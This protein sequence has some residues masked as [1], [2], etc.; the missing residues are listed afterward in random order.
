MN[1]TDKEKQQWI[2]VLESIRNDCL[3]S[4]FNLKRKIFLIDNTIDLT[5][6]IRTKLCHVMIEQAKVKDFDCSQCWINWFIYSYSKFDNVKEAEIKNTFKKIVK[7][8]C[9]RKE[10]FNCYII[11]F[12]AIESGNIEDI[13]N[14]IDSAIT[15]LKKD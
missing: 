7:E 8:Q 10:K 9:E 5:C 15:Y 4:S 13:I 6:K 11:S 12:K 2:D 3:L 1:L 14:V